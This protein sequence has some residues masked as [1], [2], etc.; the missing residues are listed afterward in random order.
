[1]KN[2]IDIN[3]IP[4][5]KFELIGERD[6]HDV[7]FDTKPI[8]YFQDAWIRFRKNKASVAAA[9][10][11]L[12]ILLFSIVVPLVSPYEINYSETGYSNKLPKD[13]FLMQFGIATGQTTRKMNLN[14]FTKAMAVGMGAADVNGTG[15]VT[16]EDG[17]LN[18]YSSVKVIGDPYVSQDAVYRDV[19]VDVYLEEGFRF[20][21]VTEAELE[22]MKAW[23]Q[24]TGKKLLYPMID[25]KNDHPGTEDANVW[26]KTKSG[27]LQPVSV[28]Q[29]I[30]GVV[31]TPLDITAGDKLV[32]NYLYDAQ[33]NA[34]YATPS[35]STMW[36]VRVLY[37]NYYQ[38]AHEGKEPYHLLG[39]D[40]S[41][42][43]ICVR[44][45]YGIRLSLLIAVC[46]SVINLVIGTV[47]GSIEGYFGGWVDIIMERISDVLSGLPFIVVAT[48][49]QMHLAAKVGPIA[50][51]LFSFVLTGWLGTAY[52]VRT[53]FYR[54]KN[55]EYVFAAR[56]LGASNSRLM[57]KHI[58]PNSLGT[59]I[60]SSVLVIPGVIFSESM[61]SY[62][63]I[64]AIH[65]DAGT[66]LGTMLSSASDLFTKY[67]H[68]IFFPALVISLLMIS[69]N[70][71]GNGLRDAFNPSLRGVE[72]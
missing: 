47:Y 54:F 64:V 1:M 35:D 63:G 19:S 24:A 59:I 72:D 9:C 17:Y 48:L 61:L 4:K 69:F 10:I 52:R 36:R 46:V 29:V 5:E 22:S 14:A 45:A 15:D 49:F 25:T 38:W 39:T 67:P 21:R 32:P 20:F 66:S 65:G 55:S 68:E 42:Y 7:K 58:F 41:G 11:I 51:L 8:G 56:T 43:D 28:K 62:L 70:L 2:N 16:Y 23:E 13:K 30:G 57:F 34:I 53:Q 71:F 26:Y 6:L 18:E 60:T 12:F 3:N 50:S 31:T 37:Y 44:L 40:N 27:T 33:G